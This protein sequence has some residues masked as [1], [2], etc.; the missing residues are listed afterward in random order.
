ML[1]L[2]FLWRLAL[3]GIVHWRA[4]R[5]FCAMGLLPCAR[6]I[7]PGQR[8]YDSSLPDRYCHWLSTYPFGVHR[9]PKSWRPLLV[10]GIRAGIYVVTGS[11]RRL[12][13]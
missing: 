5:T 12:L 10:Y 4:G 3:T 8:K 9:R 13:V 7:R 2:H 1:R 6:Y 11:Q